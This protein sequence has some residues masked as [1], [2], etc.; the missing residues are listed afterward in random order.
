M[1]FG[2]T[3]FG[4]RPSCSRSVTFRSDPGRAVSDAYGRKL[5]YYITLVWTA[6][7]GFLASMAPSFGLLCVA[8]FLLG[9][10]V[11][12]AM[13]TDGASSTHAYPV[14]TDARGDRAGTL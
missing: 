7:A 10:G 8:L 1:T 5:P 13:P 6:I 11:G 14:A 4:S 3:G 12:G 9:I 2:S